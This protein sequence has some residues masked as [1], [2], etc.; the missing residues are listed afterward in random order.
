MYKTLGITGNRPQKLPVTMHEELKKYL[1]QKIKSFKEQGGELLIQGGAIGVD[2]WAATVAFDLGLEVYTYAPFPQQPDKWS[3]EDQAV[4]REICQKSSL[5][6]V[7][8]EK[9]EVAKFFERNNA[10]VDDSDIMLALYTM[11]TTSGGTYSCAKYASTRK[12][13]IRAE[14][15][16]GNIKESFKNPV[17]KA[18][19]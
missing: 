10:I 6:K 5:V 2:Q 19:L 4:Y 16:E 17:F 8:G 15:T 9:Y 7:F 13:L 3:A 1:Y 11:G 18:K 14:V 12:P